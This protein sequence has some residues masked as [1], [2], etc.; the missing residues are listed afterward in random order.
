MCTHIYIERARLRNEGP[1]RMRDLESESESESESK[2]KSTSE[3]SKRLVSRTHLGNYHSQSTAGRPIDCLLL[4]LQCVNVIL[5]EPQ[6]SD[7]L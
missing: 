1:E 3:T 6:R 2:S 5:P 4:L 7:T